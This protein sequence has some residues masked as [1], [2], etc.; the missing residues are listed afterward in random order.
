MRFND[1]NRQTPIFYVL[2]SLNILF[3]KLLPLLTILDEEIRKF[4]PRAHISSL[5]Q[6]LSPHFC[7]ELTLTFLVNLG[8]TIL[9]S[10]PSRFQ[11]PEKSLEN[12]LQQQCPD[13]NQ[14]FSSGFLTSRTLVLLRSQILS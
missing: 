5:H 8:I 6:L 14:G 11:Q 4:H 3:S 12:L 1:L 10:F 9:W 7:T 13:K 2:C